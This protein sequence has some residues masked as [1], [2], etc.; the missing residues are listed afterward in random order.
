[1][2][3]YQGERNH[4]GIGN[5]L[6]QPLERADGRGPVRRREQIGSM[7]DYYYRAA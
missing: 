6:I 2:A 7:L 3:H 1:V 4:Q 5:R